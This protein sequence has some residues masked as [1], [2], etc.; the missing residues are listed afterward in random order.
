[1]LVTIQLFLWLAAGFALALMIAFFVMPKQERSRLV[2]S[3][4]LEQRLKDYPQSAQAVIIRANKKLSLLK[5]MPWVVTLSLF[6][7]YTFWFRK[8]EAPQCV[9]VLGQNAITI[10]LLLVCYG[11]P[12]A[13]LTWSLLY[14]RTGL[15]TLKTGY[16]PPLDE[17]R[18]ADTIATRGWLSTIRGI[19]ILLMPLFSVA[20]LYF[21][22]SAYATLTDTIDWQKVKVTCSAEPLN[23]AAQ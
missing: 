20:T 11:L 23:P 4:P 12:L 21:G 15:K 18:F 8:L 1:M 22:N 9:E 13:V 7:A 2:R 17:K 3:V 14:V 16:Y 5:E 19:A 6:S 10:Q